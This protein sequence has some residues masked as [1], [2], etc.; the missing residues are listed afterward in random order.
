METI[1]HS[2]VRGEGGENIGAYFTQDKA[3]GSLRISILGEG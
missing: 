3:R 1:Q 2:T